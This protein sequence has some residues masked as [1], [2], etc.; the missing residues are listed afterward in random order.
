MSLQSK[1]GLGWCLVLY[2]SH[3]CAQCVSKDLRS[4]C[5]SLGMCVV[6]PPGFARE[7]PGNYIGMS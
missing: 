2:L 1:E 7:T 6:D 4:I 5:I 3:T